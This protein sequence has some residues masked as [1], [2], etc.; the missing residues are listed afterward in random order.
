MAPATK[1]QR[2]RRKPRSRMDPTASPTAMTRMG[3]SPVQNLDQRNTRME[4]GEE[5]TIQKAAPSAETAGETKRTAARHTTKAA[6]ARVTNEERY[7]TTAAIY[8]A[9]ARSR[10]R[11]LYTDGE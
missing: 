3:T 2:N 6:M 7:S 9:D 5:R 11:E 1:T 8:A 4:T 10:T